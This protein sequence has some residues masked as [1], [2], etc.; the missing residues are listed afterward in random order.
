VAEEETDN[1]SED[2]EDEEK[3]FAKVKELVKE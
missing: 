3:S 1:E 2:K